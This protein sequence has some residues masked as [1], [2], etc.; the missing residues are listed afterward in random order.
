MRHGGAVT[1]AVAAVLVLAASAVGAAAQATQRT[2]DA[3]ATLADY[4]YAN[5]SFRGL[6]V[7]WGYV[8][9]TRVDATQS[10]GVRA[11]LGYLGPGVRIVPS[12]TYWASHFKRSEV[13]KL[14]DRVADLMVAQGEPR[15]DI[16]L[17]QI[18][19]SDVQLAVDAQVVWR[20]PYGILSYLGGGVSAHVLQGKGAAIDGTFVQ[21]LLNEVTA[22]VDVQAGMEYPIH[23]RLRLYGQGRYEFTGDLRY[24]QVRLGATVMF[25]HPAP[26]EERR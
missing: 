20:I 11:D 9:P 4:D 16:D 13:A 15:P 24:A 14:E 26:G 10:L 17:G 12:V 23:N 3:H 18:D 6:G 8:F 19:W 25:G 22:G 7:E 5:L 2:G 1:G 21:D